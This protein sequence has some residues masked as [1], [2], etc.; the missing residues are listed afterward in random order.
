MHINLNNELGK[1]KK[2]IE[3]FHE[4]HSHICKAS[5]ADQSGP[6]PQCISDMIFLLCPPLLSRIFSYTIN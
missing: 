4:P 5:D 1:A 3:E 6:S 2:K